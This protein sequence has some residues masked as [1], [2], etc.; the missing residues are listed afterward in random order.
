MPAIGMGLLWG[1][2]TLLF[3]G[4]CKIKGYDIGLGEIVIPG[5]WDG[6]WPPPLVKDDAPSPMGGPG[7][8]GVA[9]GDHPGDAPWSYTDPNTSGASAK[10]KGSSSS[11]G[12]V[13]NA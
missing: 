8:N 13:F 4:F 11:G 1:G 6:H 2:Y 9:P 3:W 12:G 5:K 10:G 7:H